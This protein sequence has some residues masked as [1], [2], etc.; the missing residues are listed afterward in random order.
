MQ[1]LSLTW[2][3]WLLG[4]VSVYWLL[5]ASVRQG[6]L[7]GVAAVFLGVHSPPSLVILC[8]F[9]GLLHAV[10]RAAKIDPIIGALGPLKIDPLPLHEIGAHRTE[11]SELVDKVGFDQAM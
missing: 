1:F 3:A 9:T 4:T 6:F 10:T 5:P 2:F 11:A 8:V 7:I